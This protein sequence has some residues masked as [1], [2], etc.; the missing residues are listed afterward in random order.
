MTNSPAYKQVFLTTSSGV[1]VTSS[2]TQQYDTLEV[3]AAAIGDPDYMEVPR[4]VHTVN[5]RTKI[6]PPVSDGTY[7]T[8]VVQDT[9]YDTPVVINDKE[10]L[11]E[12]PIV[13]TTTDT[14]YEVP[15]I[16]NT[17]DN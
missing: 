14:G 15:T 1:A 7:N 3:S 4:E 10:A 13:T 16:G 12:T 2:D 8:P 6:P 5:S 11:Y 17:S 9:S